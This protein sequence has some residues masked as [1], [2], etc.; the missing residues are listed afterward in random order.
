[1][2]GVASRLP[3]GFEALDPFVD[4]WDLETTDQRAK[5][6]LV[7][8]EPERA[9]FYDAAKPLLPV[10][11]GF[12]DKK[13]LGQFDERE[14]RLMNLMLS[15]A[16]VSLAVEVQRGNEAKHALGARHLTIVR[17]PAVAP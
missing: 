6:R 3:P 11:L 7:V 2:S 14:A 10:A 13:P 12:L 16:H 17:S 15:L 4:T 9:A 1:M 5:R 8:P